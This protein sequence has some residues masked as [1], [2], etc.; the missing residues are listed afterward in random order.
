MLK[1]SCPGSREIRQ[2]SPE[3]IPCRNCGKS[4]EI[5]SDETETNCGHCGGVVTRFMGPNCID[6]CPHAR[7]CIGT[8][9]YERLSK[10]EK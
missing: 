7:E 1:E 5:W 6:W 10:R 3:E 9:K 2:P 4:V 8:E